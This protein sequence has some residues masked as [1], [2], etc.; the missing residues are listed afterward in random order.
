MSGSRPLVVAISGRPNAG[1]ST[2]FNRLL[3]RKKAIVHDSPGVTRDENRA[4]LE[5][6]GRT[7]ELVDTGGIEEDPLQGGLGRRVHDRTT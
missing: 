4:A 3:K 1:K 6:D 2:L 7:I 5:R